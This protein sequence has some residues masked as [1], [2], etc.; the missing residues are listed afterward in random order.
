VKAI[1]S[2][3]SNQ[4][5]IDSHRIKTG[6]ISFCSCQTQQNGADMTQ[7]ELV[8]ASKPASKGRKKKNVKWDRNLHQFPVA[9]ESFNWIQ[10]DHPNLEPDTA[11]A[12]QLRRKTFGLVMGSFLSGFLL[13]ILLGTGYGCWASLGH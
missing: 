9:S 5:A 11:Q 8:N 1:L 3:T 10:L 13:G 4:Q 2:Q 6:Q 12:F 7:L